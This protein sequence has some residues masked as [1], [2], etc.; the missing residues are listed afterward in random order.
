MVAALYL[1][2]YVESTRNYNLADPRRC[3]ARTIF[4]AAR[5]VGQRLFVSCDYK[6][7]PADTRCDTTRSQVCSLKVLSEYVTDIQCI[8]KHGRRLPALLKFAANRPE[9]DN[10]LDASSETTSEER[11]SQETSFDLPL[12]RRRTQKVGM[13]LTSSRRECGNEGASC[14]SNAKWSVPAVDTL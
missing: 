1:T 3:A 13:P 8:N 10:Q 14:L 7:Q 12:W 2:L 5:M 6:R 4:T 11:Q 9:V